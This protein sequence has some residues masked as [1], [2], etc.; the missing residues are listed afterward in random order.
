[1]PEDLESYR[2]GYTKQE[3]VQLAFRWMDSLR[4]CKFPRR[5]ILLE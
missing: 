3:T 1:M 5:Y 2:D 4:S